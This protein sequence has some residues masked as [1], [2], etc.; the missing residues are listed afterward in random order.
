MKIHEVT[1]PTKLAL[2]SDSGRDLNWQ[3]VENDADLGQGYFGSV[4]TNPDSDSG[5]ITAYKTAKLDYNNPDL[6]GYVAYVNALKKQIDAHP[7]RYLPQIHDVKLVYDPKKIYP[8]TGYVLVDMELL[9]R[10]TDMSGEELFVAYQKML[11]NPQ[12]MDISQYHVYTPYSSV[13]KIIELIKIIHEYGTPRDKNLE[14]DPELV[15]AIDLIKGI[16]SRGFA[17]DMHHG[18]VMFRRTSFGP[19]TV[20]TDPLSFGVSRYKRFKRGIQLTVVPSKK[21]H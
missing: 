15:A 14:P 2:K 21:T 6:D 3:D 10:G 19:Q 11:N 16:S 9:T 1:T 4:K 17:F 12:H 20:L 5:Q 8:Q 18:N 13:S 7:N